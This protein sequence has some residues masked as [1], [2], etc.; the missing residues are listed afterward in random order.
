M[1]LSKKKPLTII[2]ISL[3]ILFLKHYLTRLHSSRMRTARALTVSP[4]MLCT[5]GVSAP[6]EVSA[7]QWGCLLW[8][9]V[10]F[11]GVY[12]VPGGVWSGGLSAPGGCLLLGGVPVDRHVPVNIL[13]LPQ[14]S[15]AG[16][17]DLPHVTNRLE[18]L[19]VDALRALLHY[20]KGWQ[21][22]L[23]FLHWTHSHTQ[24]LW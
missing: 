15:F 6:G 10:C 3:L 7:P 12:L 13:P 17:N 24:D 16:G 11:W 19:S 20:L 5:W 9:G 22:Q 4:S 14:T 8:R 21:S 1:S 2:W 23:L 18:P